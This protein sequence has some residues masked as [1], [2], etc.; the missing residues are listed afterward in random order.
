[1]AEN[2]RKTERSRGLPRRLPVSEEAAF[3]DEHILLS[4]NAIED[5]WFTSLDLSGRRIP[6]IRGGNVVFDRVSFANSEV[7]VVRLFDA[8][9]VGCDLSNAMFRVSE[10]TRVEFV[11]CRL[12]GLN[13]FACRF[14]DVLIERCDARFIQLSEGR[15]RRSE[16]V[17]SDFTE[18]SLNRVTFEVT[19]LRKV[20]LRRAD[21]AE[22]KLAGLDLTIC[23]IE[24]ISLRVEDLRGAIVNPAQ[25]MDLARFLEVVVK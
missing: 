16:I 5:M 8:R 18:A 23:D 15:I 13:A 1:M 11:D 21:L 22:A 6:A 19:Q 20:G 9:F 24:G 4:G 10:A 2:T 3:G 12:T 17:E 14:E 25:A 7:A